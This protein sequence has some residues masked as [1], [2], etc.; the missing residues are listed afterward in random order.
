MRH[1]TITLT[2]DVYGHL[3]SGQEAD[4]VSKVRDLFRGP[5]FEKHQATGK[6][7]R[8]AQPMAQQSV[9]ETM[10]GGARQCD[11]ESNRTQLANG[12]KPLEFAGL[13]DEMQDDAKVP[14]EG[15]EPSTL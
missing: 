2:M 5:T 12:L 7:V 6:D 9:R 3:F 8:L 15:L 13:G 4:A 10:Q 14:P 11:K 1:S